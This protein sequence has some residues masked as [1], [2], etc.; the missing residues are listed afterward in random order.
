MTRTQGTFR[1]RSETQYKGTDWSL[2]SRHSW[3]KQSLHLC[4]F[5]L[6]LNSPATR[7]WEERKQL[8]WAAHPPRR[9]FPPRSI[10]PLVPSS[11]GGPPQSTD[12]KAIKNRHTM[13]VGSTDPCYYFFLLFSSYWNR[14]K[15]L[16]KTFKR[17]NRTET[18]SSTA[19]NGSGPQ[20]TSEVRVWGEW[21]TLGD[22]TA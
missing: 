10:G 3:R 13:A 8:P 15:F 14:P 20:T 4:V 22:L 16:D 1:L 12:T 7:H 19:T 18:C 5:V 9:P 17:R 11:E 6:H 21:K 2:R